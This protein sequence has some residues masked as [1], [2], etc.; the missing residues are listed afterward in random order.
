MLDQSSALFFLA[1]V[2]S[3][4]LVILFENICSDLPRHTLSTNY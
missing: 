2:N 4:F 3:I 1:E